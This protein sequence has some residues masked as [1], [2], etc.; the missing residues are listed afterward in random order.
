MVDRNFQHKEDIL[1]SQSL[2]LYPAENQAAKIF[3]EWLKEHQ[4]YTSKEVDMRIDSYEREEDYYG[5]GGGYDRY[6]RIYKR[7]KET[8]DEHNARIRQE[9]DKYYEEYRNKVR[10]AI[11]EL[12]R[13]LNIYP[14]VISDAITSKINEVENGIMT[15]T[16]Q[17]LKIN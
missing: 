2:N 14:N 5:N 9:E 6:V 12:I 3:V 7:R 1:F 11:T 8:Q 15:Y 10:F 4:E 17:C 13:N 16:K